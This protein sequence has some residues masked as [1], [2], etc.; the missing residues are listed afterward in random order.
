MPQV[1]GP[2]RGDHD[3]VVEESDPL[4]TRCPP[5]AVAGSGRPSA[6]RA[7]DAHRGAVDAAGQQQRCSRASADRRPPP[8]QPRAGPLAR[9]ASSTCEAR[10][11]DGRDH[12]G[13]LLRGASRHVATRT[14]SP[15]D[16]RADG[17]QVDGRRTE[18]LQGISRVVHHRAAGGVE[19]GVDHERQPGPPLEAVEHAGDQRLLAAVDGLHPSGAVDVDDGGDA[20]APLRARRRARRACTARAADPRPKISGA[21][22][23]S[24]IGATGRNCSRPLTSFS[25]SRLRGVPGVREQRAVAEGPRPELAAALEPGHDAVVGQDGGDRVGQVVRALERHGGCRQ[26]RG[27]LV[28]GPAATEVGTGHARCVVT[29]GRGRRAGRRR[30]P[31]PSRRPPAAPTRA[32]TAPR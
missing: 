4:G 32:R 28:V 2:R 27:D 30:A 24:T 17:Q 3:V 20:V 19:A 13:Y 22:S 6:T 12:H 18:A 26:P 31:C 25:R 15:D 29:Q 8:R 7:D 11:A 23:A 9:L 5:A 21:R 1:G 14:G 10:P 16:E